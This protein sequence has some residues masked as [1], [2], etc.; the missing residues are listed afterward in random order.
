MVKSPGA[1]RPS[2]LCLF[3]KQAGSHLQVSTPEGAAKAPPGRL[4]A[5]DR[6][7]SQLAMFEPA[8]RGGSPRSTSVLAA[9]SP[10]YR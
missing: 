3:A 5:A 4:L 8:G 7:L 6:G 2:D 10:L 1:L 9:V